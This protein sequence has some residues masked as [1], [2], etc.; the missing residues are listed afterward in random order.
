MKKILLIILVMFSIPSLSYKEC[1]MKTQKI[2]VGDDGYMWM[3]FVNGG[4]ANMSKDDIDFD[5]TYSLLPAAQMAGKEVTIRFSSDSAVCNQGTRSD[6]RS[7]WVH[8]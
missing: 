8:R 7:V 4:V 2:F 1:G 6:I 5:K 3:M